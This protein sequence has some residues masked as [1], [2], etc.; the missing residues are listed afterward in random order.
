MSEMRGD[1]EVHLDG[2]V[3]YRDSE[4][5]ANPNGCWIWHGQRTQ[6]GYGRLVID[7]VQVYA[8]RHYYEQA[9]GSIP[10]G[11]VI[12]H[13]CRTPACVNPE[14]LEAVTNAENCRRG[15]RAQFTLAEIREIR[16]AIGTYPEIAE[17]YGTSAGYIGSIKRG[18]RWGDV[19]GPV[20]TA[21]THCKRGHPR[22][23]GERDCSV[24][25]RLRVRAKHPG[26][27]K[28]LDHRRKIAE[29]KRRW[30]AEKKAAA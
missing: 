18:V 14:H 30:W 4:W 23:E 10:Q 16:A 26:K 20:V 11:F 17:R 21:S 5:K 1:F 25:R 12:D 13:L 3:M 9:K 29:A 19:G 6:G 15:L 28:S 22:V 8:H 2:A 27:P 24:C 7:G